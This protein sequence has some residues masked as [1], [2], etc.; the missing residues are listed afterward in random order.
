MIPTQ[1]FTIEKLEPNDIEKVLEIAEECGLAV[2]KRKDYQEEIER[3][4]SFLTGAKLNNNLIG[5]IAVRIYP[6]AANN[7]DKSNLSESA[8]DILNIGVLKDFQGRGI[9][10]LLLDSFLERAH[11]LKIRNIWLEVRKSNS[12]ARNFYRRKKFIEIYE[13]EN[14]YTQPPEEA[15]VMKLELLKN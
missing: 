12:T 7:K 9:G 6:P 11:E 1:Q 3:D 15:V 14:F 13:R 4:N 5:F 8:A 2:W 10:S